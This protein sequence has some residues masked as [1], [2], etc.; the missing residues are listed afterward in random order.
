MG[1]IGEAFSQ[2]VP[3][4]G[5]AGTTYASTI[6]AIL[7]EVMSRLST[8][9][10]VGSI[11]AALA[12]LNMNNRAVKN[13][14]YVGFYPQ[15]SAPTGVPYGRITYAAGEFYLVTEGGVIQLTAGGELNAAALAGIG[16]DYGGSDPALVEFDAGAETYHFWD[17]AGANQYGIVQA[18]RF[19]VVDEASGFE[20]R[21]SVPT[22]IADNYTF[23]LPEEPPASGTSLLAFT[24]TGE[25]VFAEDGNITGA[26]TNDGLLHGNKR[27]QFS[28]ENENLESGSRSATNL[29]ITA[30][31]VNTI[32]SWLV[33]GLPAYARIKSVSFRVWKSSGGTAGASINTYNTAD[34]T[35][36]TYESATNNTSAGFTTVTRT[37]ATPLQLSS[38]TMLQVLLLLPAVT[39]YVMSYEIVYDKVV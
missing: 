26:L 16:G 29:K 35:T 36:A 1:A 23:V 18:R 3:A 7:T 27:L 15:D 5:T 37:C 22:T 6:N 8:K 24:S 32:L 30:G 19:D 33:S 4:V 31:S 2:S 9:V 10:P 39:D 20:A 14:G 21:V 12:D 11:A 25:V 17:D 34:G 28:T 38:G 13:A